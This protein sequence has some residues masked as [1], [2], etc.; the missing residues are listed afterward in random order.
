MIK[1]KINFKEMYCCT[2]TNQVLEQTIYI[3]SILGPLLF[4]LYINDTLQALSNTNTYLYAE[5]TSIFCQHKDF[6][7]IENALN[8]NLQMYAIGLLILSYQF[9]LVKMKQNA[10]FS[11]G[12]RTYL[13][14]T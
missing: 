6:T 12:I 8:K 11:V 1:P 2:V 7:E 4:L 9:I 13:S 5:D 10:L 3:G 14:L